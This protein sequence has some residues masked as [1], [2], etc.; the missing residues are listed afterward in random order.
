M[1]EVNDWLK[2]KYEYFI[3]VFL[4]MWFMIIIYVDYMWSMILV[5]DDSIWFMILIYDGFVLS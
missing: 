4:S 1:V 3:S 5:Y 2:D